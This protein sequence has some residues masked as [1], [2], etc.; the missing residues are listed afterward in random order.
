MISAE[1]MFNKVFNGVLSRWSI[2]TNLRE[3]G[4]AGLPYAKTHILQQRTE[5]VNQLATAPEYEGIIIDR[6]KAISEGFLDRFSEMMTKKTIADFQVAIDAASLVFAHTILDNAAFGFCRA[7]AIAAPSDW[8]NF[9]ERKKIS[10]S[11]LKGKEYEEVRKEKLDSFFNALERESLLKKIELLF[12]ICKPPRGF[13]PM[14][15]YT[16][17]PERIKLFD[18]QRHE[19]V[20]NDKPIA[21]I[22]VTD[23]DVFYLQKTCW[24]LMMLVNHRHNLKL[25]SLFYPRPEDDK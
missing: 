10:L 3:V 9:I 25:D 23:E 16:Y 4:H 21:N 1:E 17:D 2:I 15:D 5:F 12:Q 8:E 7:A 14:D 11:E 6:E 19:I 18:D 24:F 22:N 20:H 13:S